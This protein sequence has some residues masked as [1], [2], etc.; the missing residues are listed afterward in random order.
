MILSLCCHTELEDVEGLQTT[1]NLLPKELSSE[2]RVFNQLLQGLLDLHQPELVE[3]Y[4]EQ[5][6]T[7][8]A[9]ATVDTYRYVL[10]ALRAQ[11]K[12]CQL[13]RTE[14]V[15]L[16][17]AEILAA[18][19]EKDLSRALEQMRTLREFSLEGDSLC[20]E[21]LLKAAASE[22]RV[23]ILEEVLELMKELHQPLSLTAYESAIACSATVQD[24]ALAT[25]YHQQFKA[26]VVPSVHV[27]EALMDGFLKP[28]TATLAF[29][30]SLLDEMHQYRIKPTL[31]FFRA[32]ITFL[33]GEGRM[34]EALTY[35]R[36]MWN[37]FGIA[38]DETVDV[39][40]LDGFAQV[41]DID[42][43]LAYFDNSSPQMHD[44][45]L[46]AYIRLGRMED[47]F[48]CLQL[49]RSHSFLP[50][51]ASSTALIETL[52]GKVAEREIDAA[53]QI[54]SRWMDSILAPAPAVEGT[55]VG[56]E[57]HADAQKSPESSAALT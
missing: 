3:S 55:A 21:L 20:Q 25:E 17:S 32:L 11:G 10:T 7:A 26:E 8:N 19:N 13:T 39:K 40:M 38:P 49:M 12:D 22:G 42:Q 48:D 9:S 51:T 37:E 56:G 35:Y 14:F 47:A 16:A 15:E 4:F 29:A 28:G 18:V 24:V 23:D 57:G 43:A 34:D 30:L 44:V 33:V 45:L 54:L 31:A 1:Y 27:Y 53:N 36:R 52:N 2:P 41:G 50:S 6:R 5:L 46:A